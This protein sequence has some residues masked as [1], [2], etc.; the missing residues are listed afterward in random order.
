MLPTV[1]DPAGLRLALSQKSINRLHPADLAEILEE[2][3]PGSRKPIFEALEMSTAARVLSELDDPKVRQNLI[4]GEGDTE[5]AA[6]LLETMPPD[7]AADVLSELPDEKAQELLSHMQPEDAR[8]VSTLMGHE[9]DT[10]GALMTTEMVTFSRSLTVAEAFQRLRELAPELEF[11][12]QFYVVD[13]KRRLIGAVN[14][15]RLFLGKESDRLEQVMAPWTICVHPED[16]ASE[17]AS[18]IEKYNLA[19]VPVVDAG[20]VLVGMI[21]VDDVLTEVLPLAWKKKL[22]L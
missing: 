18:V 15:R 16:S 21:T 9:E 3:P 17:V 11:L 6:D 22:R 4:A 13:E 2:L 7:A 12:Y 19:A 14:V 10:A 5:R 8:T 1:A 20:G